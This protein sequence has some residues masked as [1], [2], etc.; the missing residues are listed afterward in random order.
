MTSSLK[1]LPL[2]NSRFP[3]KQF[4]DCGMCIFR[5]RVV[6]S[7]RRVQL[8]QLVW[9]CCDGNLDKSTGR[10][11]SCIKDHQKNPVTPLWLQPVLVNRVENLRVF[12][13]WIRRSNSWIN[14][15]DQR[16]LALSWEDQTVETAVLRSMYS[17]SRKPESFQRAHSAFQITLPNPI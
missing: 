4:L 10:R 12:G 2:E 6:T 8:V 7:A 15:T 11:Y 13:L 14:F 9:R 16:H 5:W 1:L 17:H 3:A